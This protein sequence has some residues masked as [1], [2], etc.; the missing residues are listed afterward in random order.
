MQETC[1]CSG[2]GKLNCG[3]C[4]SR[5]SP[6]LS[7]NNVVE[8]IPGNTSHQTVGTTTVGQ[9]EE[10][11]ANGHDGESMTEPVIIAGMSAR[12]EDWN[13]LEEFADSLLNGKDLELI[14]SATG[15]D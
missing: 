7:H 11:R 1:G 8:N 6:D 13:N 12:L 10:I 9:T 4:R 14:S 3:K 2:V 15:F 5:M